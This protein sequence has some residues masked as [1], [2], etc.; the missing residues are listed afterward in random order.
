MFQSGSARFRATGKTVEFPGYLRAHVYGSEDPDAE[1]AGREKL[2]PKLAQGEQ[3]VTKQCEALERNTQPPA[4]YTE[5]SLIKELERLG[6]GRPSTWATIV[7][8]VLSRSY[9]FKKGTTLVPTFI[10]MAVA[11]LARKALHQASRL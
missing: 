1:L 7:D 3:V 6:I 4:R 9:A 5:G 10:A 11:G 2:L 8:L